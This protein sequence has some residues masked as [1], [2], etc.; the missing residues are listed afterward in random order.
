MPNFSWGAPVATLMILGLS[1][2]RVHIFWSV[3][4]VAFLALVV[5]TAANA[6]APSPTFSKVFTP[7]V[8][9]TSS[10]ST[11]T[12]T[13]TNGSATPITDLAFTDVLPTV[14]GDVDIADPANASTDCID[15]IV[16]APDSG[17]T[18]TFSDGQLGAGKSCTVTVDVTASTPGAHTNPAVTLTFKELAGDPPESLPVDL[19]VATNRPG[20]AKNFTPSSIPRGGRSTLTFTIDNSANGSALS[21]LVFTDDFPV[22]LEIADPANS[23]TT[24]GG[25]DPILEASPGSSVVSF[26]SFGS[27]FP[28]FEVLLAGATCTITVDVI[29]TASGML[30]NVTSELTSNVG[31]SG[32]ASDTLEV[33]VTPLALTKS[34]TDDPVPPGGIPALEFTIDNFD[35]NFSATDIA[36]SDDLTTLTPALAGLTF[37]SLLSND[38]GGSISGVGGTTIDFSGGTL[39]PQSSCTIGVS[40]SVPVGATPGTYSNTTGAITATVDG[41]PVTGN[42]ATDVLF[43]EPSPLLTKIFMGDPVNPGDTVVLEFT[44]TNTSTT[45][46][47]TD[48]AFEDLFNSIFATASVTPGNDCCG[49]GSTCTFTPLFNPPP[50]SDVTPATLAISGGSLAPAGMPGGSCTFSITL[51]V[52]DDAAPGLYP[53]TTSEIT[54]TVDGDTRT[55]DPASDTLTVIAAPSLTKS[56][57]DDPVAPGG[58]VTL[59]FTLSYPPDASGDATGISFTDDLA[60]VL[61]GLT[62]T[63]LPLIEACDPDGPGGDSGTGTLSGSAGDTLLTFTGGTLSPGESCVISVSLAVPAVATSGL[64]TNTT[65]GVGATVEGLAATSAPASDDLKVAGLTFTK[66]FIGDPAFPGETV[67]LRFTFENISPA[68][69]ATSITF[70]DDLSLVLPGASDLT[71]T[72]PPAVNTCGGSLST[73]GTT[74]LY[75]N[76]SLTVGSTCTIDVEVLVPA[77]TANGIYSNTTSAFSAILDGSFF[78]G[79]PATDYLT[80]NTNLLSLIK[81]FTDDPVAPGGTVTL[82]FTLTNLDAGQAASAIGFTDDLGAALTGL[83]FDSVLFNDCGG[84]VSGTDSITVSGVSLAAGGSCTLRASL[85]VPGATAANIYTN[86]T[87]ALSGTI[88]GFAVTGDAASDDLEVIQLLLFSKSFDGPT[89]ASGTA[90]LTFT[91]TNP[92]TDTA[93]DI[94]FSDDLSN[95]IS[96][97][98]ATSLPSQ[99]CGMGSSITGVSF[100]TFNGGVLPPMGG[101]C[102]FDVELLV[103]AAATAGTFPNTT[104]DLFRAGLRVADPATA[105]LTVEPPPLFS[106]NFAPAAMLLGGTST[107][108]LTIDNTVSVLAASGLDVTDNLPTGVVIGGPAN[109]STTCTGGTL[110]A[111]VGTGTVS[112][113]GGTVG[114]AASCTVQVDVTSTTSGTHVNTTGDLTSS[115]GNS[116]TAGATLTVESPPTFS[117]RFTPSSIGSGSTSTLAFTIDNTTGSLAVDNLSFTDDLPAGVTIDFPANGVSTCTGGTLSAPDGGFSISYTGGQVAADSTCTISVN[118]TSSS[119]GM[120]ANT[121]GDLTSNAGNSGSAT[122][123]LTVDATLPGFIKSF[124][125]SQI[126]PGN[127]SVLTLTID[128]MTSPAAVGNLAFTDNLPAGMVIATPANASTNCSG[129]TLTAAAG[130]SSITYSNGTVA[131]GA[132][133]TVQTDI[134]INTVGTYV[135]TT[136]D[137][138]SDAGSSGFV[139]AVLTAVDPISLS[140]LFSDDPVSPGGTVTLAFTITNFDRTNAATNIAFSDDLD[141]VLLGLV[142]TGLPADGFCGAGSQMT[143]TSLLAMSGGNLAPEGTCMFDVTLHVPVGAAAGTFPNTTS[144]VTADINGSGVSGDAATDDLVIEFAPLLTKTFTDDPVAAGGT[145]TLEFTII[146]TDTSGGATDIA[147]TDDLAALMPGLELTLPADGFC[148]AGATMML[149]APPDPPELPQTL[150]MTGGSLGAGASCTFS[151]ILDLPAS[152]PAGTFA[153][154]TSAITATVGGMALTGKAA[155]DSLEVVAAPILSKSFI[156]DPVAP[157]G[158]VTLEFTLL[159]NENASADA[160]GI[161]FTDDL[162][163]TLSGLTATGLP[164]SDVCGVGSQIDGDSNLTFSHGSLAPGESCTFSIALQ[165]PDGALSGNHINTTSIVTASVDGMMVTGNPASDTLEV[166]GLSISKSFTDDPVVPGATVTL[167]FTLTNLSTLSNATMIAFTDDLD[168]V[169]S[170][171]LA[172]GLPVS[173]SCGAGSLIDGTSQLSFRG[174]S[175]APGES[176]TLSVILQ[177]PNTAPTGEYHNSTSTLTANIEGSAVTISPASDTLTVSDP[178]FITKAF[179]DDPVFPGAT[180]TLEFTI[181]NA[182]PAQAATGIAFTDDLEASLT[183]LVA[184]GLPAND[185]CGAGSQ[186]SGTNLLTFTGGSLAAGGNCTFTVTLQVPSA[187]PFGTTATNTTSQVS[188]EVGGISVVGN[189]AADD[190]EVQQLAFSKAFVGDT[191]PGGLTTLTFTI[192]NPNAF[193]SA[194]DISF[195]DDLNA[196]V[197]D[198]SAIDL[199]ANEVCGTGS[200]I[201]GTTT[202]NFTGGSLSPGASCTFSVTIQVPELA[203]PGSYVNT[204]STIQATTGGVTGVSRAAS[205]TLVVNP[206]PFFGKGFAP[207]P[208]VVGG[209]STLTF[210]VDNSANVSAAASGLDFT[211]NLPAGMLIATPANAATTC[212]GGALNATEGASTIAYSGGAVAAASSCTVL[213]D[214][215]GL[216]AGSYLNTTDLL[217]SSL[218]SSGTA[219]ATLDITSNAPPLFS[220][221]FGPAAIAE[222]EI[223]TL[224]FSI[225]NTASLADATN[226][227]FTDMLPADV[228]VAEQANAS[229]TCTGGTL[230]AES[231]TISYSGG[232]VAAGSTC[233]I[234]IDVTSGTV[235][236]HLNTTSDL[237]SSLGT[238]APASATLTVDFIVDSDLSLTFNDGDVVAGNSVAIGAFQTPLGT[239]SV[240]FQYRLPGG[241]DWIDIGTAII[242]PFF[243]VPWD[244]TVIAD[245]T[246]VELRALAHQADGTVLATPVMTVF[247]DNRDNVANLILFEDE[248]LRTQ[249]LFAGMDAT[250]VTSQGVIVDF[251]AMTFD[252]DDTVMVNVVQPAEASATPPGNPAALLA[253]IGLLSGQSTFTEPPTLRF[254]YL[255]Q[256]QDGMVD[257]TEIDE[258]DLTLWYFDPFTESWAIVIGAVVRPGA[259]VIEASVEQL[260]QYGVFAAPAPG[261][262]LQ[263]TLGLEGPQSGNPVFMTGADQNVP[264]LQLQLEQEAETCLLTTVTLVFDEPTGAENVAEQL[265]VVIYDDANGNGMVD[266][267]EMV[268][269]VADIE[270]IRDALILTFEPPFTLTPG[271]TSHFLVTLTGPRAVNMPMQ[272]GLLTIPTGIPPLLIWGM[273]SASALGLILAGRQRRGGV[274]LLILFVLVSGLALSSCINDDL[275][276]VTFTVTLPTN[277]LLCEGEIT[278]SFTVP[279]ALIEGATVTATP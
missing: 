197:P 136:G 168:S 257:D 28:G 263:V 126:T 1:T 273:I 255:D 104:S 182:D 111:V 3:L 2:R 214:V 254:S 275:D 141:A 56:F 83:T 173:D 174:G 125:P 113:T 146:N 271:E 75:S 232:T 170:G 262:T 190:L 64:Y 7:N 191:G 99:P 157:G 198:L 106:K 204:T 51:D 163:A 211:D 131:A 208:I 39:P 123:T 6:Q 177:V 96:G 37:D 192:T 244:T 135:N 9:G 42:M 258:N 172:T 20:F 167:E 272:L 237:T 38:C 181:A 249:V 124:A 24:C 46:S 14:P 4:L 87:S 224:R 153:N 105:D 90:T 248:L 220:K 109:A 10:V 278:G 16:A 54:A 269:S 201:G 169:L 88:D 127:T 155:T 188:G 234:Q 159:H 26:T 133:C 206:S 187:V 63:S 143:G 100:L 140:K 55:G 203:T 205:A 223:S 5:V 184:V 48:I 65:S 243:F 50:P 85:S 25:P 175:L 179:T 221:G 176:C 195:S 251:P 235:G 161:S 30:D 103:P 44:V 270:E 108:T 61:V 59:E 148:G 94:S 33:T 29:A 36:F 91:I 245:E 241:S 154:T 267:D 102:S 72:L 47:A 139:S 268:L 178:L 151:V 229:T 246:S 21:S 228:V 82:E 219:S 217:V 12:F 261:T 60:P 80:V 116:G 240:V 120:H 32:K 13:I 199:P 264:V 156:D 213:V 239:E 117:K 49:S 89:T 52:G 253:D 79:D 71:P 277:G 152:A 250:V 97:L 73:I 134:T 144:Q 40:L 93:T 53:N 138:T 119:L 145:V 185:V 95:V 70:T 43:V 86:T 196:A 45:S 160:T 256:D 164:I 186:I 114:A 81:T 17:G 247:V 259:N 158:V 122:A 76:G 66:A 236:E 101:T 58:T 218:G 67:T 274:A 215:I 210:T 19:T 147:F 183:G 34:F 142:A 226:L 216:S 231:G 212:T 118:V 107:L 98:V 78:T 27:L 233:T 252:D 193:N 115:S 41:S 74:L 110:S 202:L 209:V 225:D 62:S 15:G 35:R 207:S 84:S 265:Q 222:G 121:S 166:G 227:A 23:S 57:T 132:T 279:E 238:S 69:D 112:Y 189:S 137:L 18:I 92:G 165:I 260:G 8:I 129:G 150:S 77:G 68:D 194:T 180:V 22:G 242:G 162:D 31:S 230:S 130:A 276:E 128:N 171:L 11:I 266:P 149:I 200:Q